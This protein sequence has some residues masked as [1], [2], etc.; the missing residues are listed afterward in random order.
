MHK[1]HFTCGSVRPQE[2]SFHICAAS[3]HKWS[4]AVGH[5]V[6]CQ[7]AAGLGC[8][9]KRATRSSSLMQVN[10][11]H[12]M[13]Y[14]LLLTSLTCYV[15]P[16]G[17]FRHLGR[18]ESQHEQDASLASDRC[19]LC[20]SSIG[21]N[22]V[23]AGAAASER[24][25]PQRPQTSASTTASAQQ[26]CDSEDNDGNAVGHAKAGV[27]QGQDC[28]RWFS[29]PGLPEAEGRAVKTLDSVSSGSSNL[30]YHQQLCTT[31]RAS[32]HTD[33][34]VRYQ[35]LSEAQDEVMLQ[36]VQTGATVRLAHPS[37]ADS[38]AEEP[39]LG[40]YGQALPHGHRQRM[41]WQRPRPELMFAEQQ[42]W[43]GSDHR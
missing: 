2:A 22:H 20:V 25:Q 3:S 34:A 35:G 5:P 13:Q 4:M 42:V 36:G 28:F 6:G 30:R 8:S 17:S 29:K 24:Q 38:P 21:L 9:I 16:A 33:F 43:D 15:P 32:K 12:V 37:P 40:Q 18:L 41:T 39:A 14:T 10:L 11:K 31:A 23:L 7:S 1:K 19:S 26:A 27:V